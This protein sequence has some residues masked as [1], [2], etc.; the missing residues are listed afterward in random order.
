MVSISQNTQI[1]RLG[2]SE[3]GPNQDPD[4][5]VNRDHRRLSDRN[6]PKVKILPN[7][8]LIKEGDSYG[9][10]FRKEGNNLFFP[11]D[12]LTYI[13]DANLHIRIIIIPK[14]V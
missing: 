9:D 12:P 5:P 13:L 1:L 10:I 6:G 4:Y 8:P 3:L 7:P 2:K 11:K 14:E